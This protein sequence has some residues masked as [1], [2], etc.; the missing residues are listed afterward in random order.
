MLLTISSTAQKRDWIVFLTMNPLLHIDGT[1]FKQ[2]GENTN[3][4]QVKF[5]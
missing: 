3:R 2:H 5:L 4:S 1:H